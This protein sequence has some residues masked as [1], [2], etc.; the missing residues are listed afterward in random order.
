MLV[1]MLARYRFGRA[2]EALPP[3]LQRDVGVEPERLRR[4]Y[5]PEFPPEG[6]GQARLNR[7]IGVSLLRR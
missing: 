4:R 1:A 5:L 6:A 3:R 7:L 2:V